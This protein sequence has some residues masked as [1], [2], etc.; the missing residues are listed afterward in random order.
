MNTYINKTATEILADYDV[1]S[2]G[3][4]NLKKY[5]RV[6]RNDI[7]PACYFAIITRIDDRV[8]WT[9]PRQ[10]DVY[11]KL[12]DA[13]LCWREVNG[14]LPGGVAVE[15]H[16]VMQ[17]YFEDSNR[18]NE[19]TSLMDDVL[20]TS[21]DFSDISDISNISMLVEVGYDEGW[22][23]GGIVREELFDFD[24]FFDSAVQFFDDEFDECL[25]DFYYDED[26]EDDD[27]FD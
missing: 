20:S 6:I 15:P 21:S 7:P 2:A 3:V 8:N 5:G 10:V 26:E 22:D 27:D 17:S 14:Y 19:F 1:D 25:E 23:V 24:D 9:G 4:S 13:S 12:Y 11:Y 16:Y 18:Y